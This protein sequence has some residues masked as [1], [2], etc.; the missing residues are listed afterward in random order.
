MCCYLPD[1][2]RPA[3]ASGDKVAREP[4]RRISVAGRLRGVSSWWW[5]QGCGGFVFVDLGEKKRPQHTRTRST[6][7]LNAAR[8]Y[9][10]ATYV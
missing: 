7:K 1:I 8:T 5:G 6:E 10:G 9:L 2:H 3:R 4:S